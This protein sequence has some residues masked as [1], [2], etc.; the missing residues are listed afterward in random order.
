[1]KINIE[2]LAAGS[3]LIDTI[4]HARY[5]ADDVALWWLGQAGF[6]LRFGDVLLL[7]D[8]YLSDSLAEKYRDAELKHL[9]MMPPPV[10]P[11]AIRG[12]DWF[13]CTHGHTDHMDAQTIAALLQHNAPRFVIPRAEQERARQRNIPLERAL[14]LNA[15]ET[16]RLDEHMAV[17]AVAAAH[18]TLETDAAGNHKFLGY[19]L[20]LGDLRLYHSGDC[21]PYAGLA[22]QL[23]NKRID[24]ALLP[25]NGRD[26]FRSSRGVPGNFTVEEAVAL[27]RAAAIPHL[28]GHHFGLF[29]FNTVDPADAAAILQQQAGDLDWLLPQ[30]GMTYLLAKSRFTS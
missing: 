2:S 15:G 1:M 22:E 6:A 8:P 4:N 14:P 7:I 11:A 21:V 25:I 18:E 5:G 27:C 9:R 24:V 3:P 13:F 30:V 12:C 16:L 23:A 17:E 26:A 29:D 10:D 20:T 28:I 19:I